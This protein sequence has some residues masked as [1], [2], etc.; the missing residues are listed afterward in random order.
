MVVL[1]ASDC[2][3]AKPVVTDAESVL[4]LIPGRKVDL[5]NTKRSHHIALQ[6]IDRLLEGGASKPLH[7][8]S[9][10]ETE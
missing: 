8:Y 6:A 4:E 5:S 10:P 3:S 1:L 2:L 9:H 7:E